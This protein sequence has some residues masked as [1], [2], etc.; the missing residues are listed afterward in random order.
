LPDR[1]LRQPS[2]DAGFC[3]TISARLP[4]IGG[5]SSRLRHWRENTILR[6]AGI[7]SCDLARHAKQLKR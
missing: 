5:R 7:W 6:N 1:A 3:L 4:D 2:Y